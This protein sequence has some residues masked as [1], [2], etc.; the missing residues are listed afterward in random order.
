MPD[1]RQFVSLDAGSEFALGERASGS[2]DCWPAAEP[3][4]PTEWRGYPLRIEVG[5]QTHV[6]RARQNNEDAY[7][8]EESLNLY[9]LSDGIGGEEQGEGPLVLGTHEDGPANQRHRYCTLDRA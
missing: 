3:V 8:I 9:V 5:A 4:V 1:S 7:Q 6:G 2:G